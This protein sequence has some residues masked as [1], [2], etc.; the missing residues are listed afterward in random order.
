LCTRTPEL[1]GACTN[2]PKPDGTCGCV[3]PPCQPVRTLRSRR[4]L[5]TLSAIAVTLGFL[6]FTLG[7]H[8][9]DRWI[10]PGRLSSAHATTEAN[11][12]SCHNITP[13][14]PTSGMARLIAN[15][16]VTSARCVT[17][18]ELGQQPFLPH[19]RPTAELAAIASRP[20]SSSGG[21]NETLILAAARSVRAP[22]AAQSIECTACHKEHSG[23][24][25]DIRKIDNNQ[26][27]VC[28]QSTFKSFSQ[29]H[30]EFDTYPYKQRTRIIFDHASHLQ[31][32][33]TDPANIAKAPASCL[34]CHMPADTQGKMLVKGF[35]QS[36][37]ACHEAQIKGDGRAGAKG[38]AF[39][40]VPG[41][42]VKTLQDK[43]R[44]VG[45]WPEY[46]EGPVNPF[47]KLL[48]SSDK[49]AATDLALIDGIDTLD[50]SSA[51]PAQL[52]A[53]ARTAW[54]IKS[55]FFDLTT[56]GQP[57]LMHRLDAVSGKT[58]LM[59]AM[60]AQ[61][62]GDTLLAAKTAWWP[63]LFVEVPN[64]RRGILPPLPEKP[65]PAHRPSVSPSTSK[66]DA[67]DDLILGDSPKPA[68]PAKS[69]PKDDI[70]GGGD[71]LA[72]DTTP[73]P[74]AK[75][76]PAPAP[77]KKPSTDDI[78]GGDDILAG[79]PPAPVKKSAPTDDIL[80]DL[81]SEPAP[82][83]KPTP[84]PA[85]KVTLADPEAWVAA[86]GWYRSDD[87]YTLYYRPGGHSDTFIQAWI[88]TADRHVGTDSEAILKVI[89]DP[90]SP[91]LCMKCH[92]VDP[93]PE[94]RLVTQWHSARFDPRNHE[95]VKFSHSA[96]F[97]LLNERGCQTCHVI[98]PQANYAS[99]YDEKAAPG[100]FHSNFQA[101]SK[102]TCATCHQ[103]NIAGDS[104]QLCHNYHQGFFATSKLP[105]SSTHIEPATPVASP[106]K[107]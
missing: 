74:T 86:G 38:I 5:F 82:A 17:C 2:G 64:Y 102:D 29:G 48:L 94:G 95:V 49:A 59:P 7:S 68:T 90:K 23:R 56:E 73:A 77:A 99:S 13:G 60:L 43:G 12:A 54:R 14:A 105:K 50:L 1:G 24:D 87:T 101:L 34:D 40:R 81:G 58:D 79:A 89:A 27:Q 69:A 80:G 97:S 83:A 85:P 8:S 66:A 88:D 44:S 20:H 61:L 39:F 9:P 25:A 103:N 76:V 51:S 28:H 84:P 6:L 22:I 78:L 92:S 96:H 67:G 42:D 18:H 26:C 104:C 15:H 52:D 107:L 65:K 100:V 36:C 19:G 91:G 11:C 55:L 93:Q 41:L 63:N 33:F 10:T 16:P 106:E 53:A 71:I 62:P 37:S 46:A 98:A 57:A 35:A 47:I 4:G 21:N 72:G 45:Q 31:K 70:L 3:I 75:P 30:P 32:H